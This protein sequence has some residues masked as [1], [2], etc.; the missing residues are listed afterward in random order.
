MSDISAATMT[1]SLDKD[2]AMDALIYAVSVTIEFSPAV[3]KAMSGSNKPEFNK[4]VSEDTIGAFFK[5]MARYP[6][7]SE[8]AFDGKCT[9]VLGEVYRKDGGW[10][11]RAI[12]DAYP[13]DSFV[14]LL[15]SYIYK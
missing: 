10:K 1:D 4:A 7:S 3:A 2:G 6:L 5:E 14:H 11:F 8:S 15:K 12:G 9:M 13:Y